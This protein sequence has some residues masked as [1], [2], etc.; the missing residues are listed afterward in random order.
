MVGAVMGELLPVLLVV[1][2]ASRGVVV[3]TPLKAQTTA[4]K[5]AV[6]FMSVAVQLGAE[7]PLC[8]TL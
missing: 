2:V 8:K 5:L 1:V 3:S 6:E 7:S 4:E